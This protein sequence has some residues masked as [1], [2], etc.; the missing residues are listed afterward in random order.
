[1][2]DDKARMPRD[3]GALLK[4]FRHFDKDGSGTLSRIELAA[5]L[6]NQSGSVPFSR[7]AAETETARIIAK[8]DSNGDGL[9]Q[10][11]EFVAWWSPS[12]GGGIS[13][14]EDE[15]SPDL[16]PIRTQGGVQV[17]LSEAGAT[18]RSS[19]V[20]PT[21]PALLSA[22]GALLDGSP[23]WMAAVDLGELH[24]ALQ[25]SGDDAIDEA[26]FCEVVGNL[27]SAAQRP[28]TATIMALF[29]AFDVDN[30]G[31]ISQAELIAGCQAMCGGGSTEKMRLAFRLFDKDGDGH[32]TAGELKL[33]LR[34]TI[35]PA[36]SSLHAAID[37]AA[38]EEG[39]EDLRAIATEAGN[40]ASLA[41]AAGGKVRVELQTKAGLAALLVPKDA[42]NPDAIGQAGSA[43]SL[44]AFLEAIVAQ[45]MADYDTDGSATLEESEFVALAGTN[46]FLRSWFGRLTEKAST[47]RTHSWKDDF[48]TT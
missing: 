1:M 27:L 41:E 29:R 45:G 7:E 33:L 3:A 5:I 18:A 46:N 36:V 4:C 16:D 39:G 10:Y 44:D 35:A 11:E 38:I 43:L 23:A 20:Q 15:D 6:C 32:I 9:L 34:G 26:G 25:G 8:F 22:D 13:S 42:L 12:T 14:T 47:A 28:P 21:S 40:A 19:I 2:C 17:A 24:T 31:S 30:S 48:E 37:F